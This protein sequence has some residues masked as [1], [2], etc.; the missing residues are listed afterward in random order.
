MVIMLIE[1]NIRYGQI[2]SIK[3][4]VVFLLSSFITFLSINI[5]LCQTAR[6]KK[7]L[8]LVIFDA[9]TTGNVLALRLP[10]SVGTRVNSGSFNQK[11]QSSFL[12]FFFGK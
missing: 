1:N 6:Y 7:N 2:W 3:L 11:P 9:I 10:A 5:S 12:L 4:F 8:W